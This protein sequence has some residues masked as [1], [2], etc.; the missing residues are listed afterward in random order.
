[1]TKVTVENQSGAF[2]VLNAEQHPRLWEAIQLAI[3]EIIADAPLTCNSNE[4]K[5]GRPPKQP[6]SIPEPPNPP[7]GDNSI[8]T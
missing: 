4:R 3:G 7:A 2:L 1:M 6:Q 5:R 8:L